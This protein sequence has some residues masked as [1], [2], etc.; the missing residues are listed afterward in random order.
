MEHRLR[1]GHLAA[2]AGAIATAAALWLPW[3][4]IRLGELARGALGRE[5]QGLPAGL[6]E[7][8]R[9]LM[10]VMP[11]SVTGTGW[12]TLRGADAALITG[13]VLVAAL[14]LAAAGMLGPGVKVDSATAGRIVGALGV[15]GAVIVAQHILSPPGPNELVHV[16]GGMW[17]ALAGTVLTAMAGLSTGAAPRESA[18]VAAAPPAFAFT[19]PIDDVSPLEPARASVA[20]PPS[21][22]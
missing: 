1:T 8:A 3:Y 18:T 17:V 16:R 12:E 5:A 22:P 4:E 19:A 6:G 21:R 10:A 11:E 7:F 20:P 14:V 15:A 9:G 2:L 13:A